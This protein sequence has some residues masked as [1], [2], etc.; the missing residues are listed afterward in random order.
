MQAFRDMIQGWFGKF[1]LWVI[2]IVFGAFGTESLIS[3]VTGPR[4]AVKVNGEPVA[5]L[6]VEQVMQR[7]RQR[8]SEMMGENVDPSL[9]E[10][11]RLRPEAMSALINRRLLQQYA[12]END[13]VATKAQIQ[14]LIQSIPQFQVEGRFSL[15]LYEQAVLR[16]GQ[17]A[18]QLERDLANDYVITQATEALFGSAFATQ[19]E[20]ASIASLQAQT[21]DLSY[22]VLNSA[23]LLAEITPTEEALKDYYDDNLNQFAVEQKIKLGYFTIDQQDF[24]AQA[25]SEVTEEALKE[26]YEAQVAR[27]KESEQR[28]PAHILVEIDDEVDQAQALEQITEIAA[29][30]AAGKPFA[31][32]AKARS[33]DVASAEVG[34][35]LGLSA[36]GSLPEPLEAVL[37][38]MA[39]EAVSEPILTEFG[40]HLVQLQEIKAAD[41][42]TFEAERAV[43]EAQL[44]QELMAEFYLDAVDRLADEVYNA[45]DLAGPAE[46]LG[47]TVATTDWL[48]PGGMPTGLFSNAA[49]LR[50]AFSP[51]IINGEFNS[52]VIEISS[53]Q[54]IVIRGLEYQPSTT[55]PFD[56][57]KAE[58]EATV[59]A[60]QAQTQLA[61][62]GRQAIAKIK[63]GAPEAEVLALIEPYVSKPVEQAEDL[64]A[65]QAA[66]ADQGAESVLPWTVEKSLRRF[67][68]KVPRDITD[69]LFKM[70]RPE[71]EVPTVVGLRLNQNDFAIVQL[72]AVNQPD[73]ETLAT[74]V[75]NLS[76]YYAFQVQQQEEQRFLQALRAEADIKV[77]RG[78]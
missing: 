17:G 59:K 21:R 58:I 73:E 7:Q 69:E 55:Q 14:A 72:L 15:P 39:L 68:A 36:R 67:S 63:S 56:A 47:K 77:F 51:E 19:P 52:E 49:L 75:E 61:D 11:D 48:T 34:G 26:A 54:S 3:I 25:Q 29:E 33:D 40:Y 78:E 44:S 13:F 24:R 4:P 31:E 38:E 64:E 28:R 8:L 42:P 32:V 60:E 1:M 5:Q 30:I 53:D 76:R 35:D 70:A 45:E 16:T 46:T 57:V 50:T 27:L 22:M 74:E 41:I 9:L 18:A 2:I 66:K 62:L 20:L 43:L 37:F 71:G 23:A 10:A 12:N 6:E 65:E